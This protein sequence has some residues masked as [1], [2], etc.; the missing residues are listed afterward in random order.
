MNSKEA[1]DILLAMPNCSECEKYG[2][3]FT[4]PYCKELK[5]SIKQ[6]LDRLEQLEKENT[7]LKQAINIL[8]DKVY[9]RIKKY[10]EKDYEN[11]HKLEV[12][13][14]YSYDL[15]QEEYELYKEVFESVGGKC[16]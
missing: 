5:D 14:D 15:T 8:K 11:P 6:D 4:K 13:M 1:L 9:L 7:K 12:E 3:C 16:D 2:E 10:C